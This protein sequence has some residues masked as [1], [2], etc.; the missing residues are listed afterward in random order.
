M[1]NLQGAD[2]YITTT[3]LYFY[4]TSRHGCGAAPL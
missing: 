2:P 1:L 3:L 4:S